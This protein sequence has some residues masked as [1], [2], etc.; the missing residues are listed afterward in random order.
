MRFAKKS[1]ALAAV[2]G[3]LALTP[4]ASAGFT[5]PS[6]LTP[7]LPAANVVTVSKLMTV[8]SYTVYSCSMG[9]TIVVPSSYSLALTQVVA[10]S[11]CSWS[12][13]QTATISADSRNNGTVVTQAQNWWN[14]NINVPYYGPLT[15]AA[16]GAAVRAAAAQQ[17]ASGSSGGGSRGAAPAAASRAIRR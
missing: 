9:S 8:G 7:F 17:A 12:K 4:K 1:L 5:P 11:N 15:S 6:S 10:S 14:A 16:R 2:A 3:F 13:F